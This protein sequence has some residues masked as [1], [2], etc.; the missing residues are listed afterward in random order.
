MTLFVRMVFLL[1]TPLLIP[2]LPSLNENSPVPSGKTLM[3]RILINIFHS[4]KSVYTSLRLHT[5]FFFLG[6]F[7]HSVHFKNS[8]LSIEPLNPSDLFSSHCLYYSSLHL[9]PRNSPHR[10][11]SGTL[12]N[13]WSFFWRKIIEITFTNYENFLSYRRLRGRD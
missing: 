13:F 4:D 9:S 11:R 8:P 10:F 6:S 3:L 5:V 7:P 1:T 12:R 2:P